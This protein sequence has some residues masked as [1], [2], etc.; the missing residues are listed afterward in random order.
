MSTAFITQEI[1]SDLDKQ[2][3]EITRVF[4]LQQANQL[5]LRKTDATT[6]RRKLQ[7]VKYWM[8]AH[9]RDIHEALYQDFKKSAVEV[10]ATEIYSTKKEIEFAL[11]HLDSWMKPKK[12]ATPLAL[13]GTRSQVMYEPKGVSLIIAPW[14]YPFYLVVSPLVSAIAA[15]CTAMV[16]PSEM[17]P[18][19]AHLLHRMLSELFPENEVAVFEG[20]SQVAETLLKLPFNHIFFTGSQAIGKVVMKAAAEHLTSV[21]LELGGKS[22]AIID[23]T[24]NLKDAAEKLVWGKWLNAGQTCVAPDYLLVQHSVQQALLT[25]IKQ[26]IQKYHGSDVATSPAYARIVNSHHHQRLLHLIKSAV[27][28]GAKVVTGGQSSEEQLY[29]APTILTEVTDE[30]EVMQQEIFGP[31]LPMMPFGKLEEA[32][33]YV[34]K[35]AKPLAIYF[36]S[37]QQE[38]AK[39]VLESTSSGGFCINDCVIHLANPHLPFGGT[40]T[41]GLGSSHGHYGFLAFSHEKAVMRQ[42]VGFTSAKVLYPPYTDRVKKM[43]ELT[44]KWL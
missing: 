23:E 1:P 3:L 4:T 2:T 19:T 15:G 28:K 26:T 24:A 31:I 33:Q 41:S 27:M 7:S 44:M 11:K 20:N 16:K 38:H 22:P 8:L 43:M 25:A 13:L 36:F 42:R 29:L 12:V 40:N 6:R 5:C 39:Q 18:N 34:N 21:T 32:I 17:T 30:M 37:Q 35:R 10:D 9:Q 14:N